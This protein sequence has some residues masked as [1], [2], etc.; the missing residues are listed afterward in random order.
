MSLRT[1][2]RLL[3][4]GA[5][6]LIVANLLELIIPGPDGITGPGSIPADGVAV[7]SGLIA[8]VG[9]PALYRMQA[10]QTG[11]AGRIGVALLCLATLFVF[12]LSSGVQLLDV[13]APGTV[14]HDRPDGPP[15]F[16][17]IF[18]LLGILAYVIGGL[19]VGIV[20]LRAHILPAGVGWL[21]IAGVVLVVLA[22]VLLP[23]DSAA[24]VL[25][26][27]AA[28]SGM[29]AAWAWAG[30]RTMA[31]DAAALAA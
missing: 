14:P 24:N 15:T 16:L 1:S 22:S 26:K 17:L 9:L 3:L 21:V 28:T 23:S 20:T 25:G 10:R 29:F 4:A 11:L 19:A 8:I 7:V 30:A 27:I 5:L 18:V 6:G 31:R 12:V 13:A 2:G